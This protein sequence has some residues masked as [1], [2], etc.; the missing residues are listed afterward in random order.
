MN[1]DE[2]LAMLRHNAEYPGIGSMN[3]LTFGNNRPAI[4]AAVNAVMERPKSRKRFRLL[5]V[6]ERETGELLAEVFGTVHGP[7]V[8]FRS[9]TVHRGVFGDQDKPDAR[10]EFVRQDRGDAN[11][12]VAPLDNDPDQ[13]F[14]LIASAGQYVLTNPELRR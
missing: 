1:H 6:Y 14:P 13:R 12:I 8:V 5:A 3:F 10:A 7:V 4:L 11:L 2:L 9:G